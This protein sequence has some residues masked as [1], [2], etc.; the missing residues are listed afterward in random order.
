MP[1]WIIQTAAQARDRETLARSSTAQ[2][3]RRFRSTASHRFRQPGHVA[4][5][6]QRIAP[7]DALEGLLSTRQ[8]VLRG[9]STEPM[10]KNG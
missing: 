4:P 9:R 5:V 10:G 2:D 3:V 8:R 1:A 6:H 7:L